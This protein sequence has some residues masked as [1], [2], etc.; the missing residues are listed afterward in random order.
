MGIIFVTKLM[1]MRRDDQLRDSV[2]ACNIINI[3]GTGVMLAARLLGH[4]VPERV[5]GVDLFHALLAMSA[6]ARFSV[7]L[8]GAEQAVV[9]TAAAAEGSIGPSLRVMMTNQ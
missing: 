7:F 9:V 8:L 2:H 5:A 3:D 1:N 4:A 6:R